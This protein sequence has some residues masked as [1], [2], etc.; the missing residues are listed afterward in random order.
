MSLPVAVMVTLL[1]L[2]TSLEGC[3]RAALPYFQVHL[4]PPH[5]LPGLLQPAARITSH[6]LA[7]YCQPLLLPPT[8]ILC[9]A[10]GQTHSTC[11]SSRLTGNQPPFYPLRGPDTA[12]APALDSHATNMQPPRAATVAKVVAGAIAARI[13]WRTGK[14]VYNVLT[15]VPPPG[16]E[17]QHSCTPPKD[18]KPGPET[19]AATRAFI[20]QHY[21]ELLDLVDRG[22]LVVLQPAAMLAS[23]LQARQRSSQQQVMAAGGAAGAAQ[24][25]E[26]PGLSQE[27]IAELL[28][29]PHLQHCM[30]QPAPDLLVFVGTVHVAKQSADDVTQVIKVRG[31]P[32]AGHADP[33]MP[34]HSSQPPAAQHACPHPEGQGW[35]CMQRLAAACMQLP[36]PP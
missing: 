14:L 25:A 2:C 6:L 9:P 29:S 26:A 34:A 17:L 33:W 4:E 20:S 3:V 13:L 31:D 19:D 27:D 32:Q 24:A 36:L 18:W 23:L 28:S 5:L 35:R 21:P 12:P 22:N 15:S 8:S 11:T 16:S 30:A 7:C 1:L 10:R